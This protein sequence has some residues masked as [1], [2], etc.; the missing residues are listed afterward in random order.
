MEL[1]LADNERMSTSRSNQSILGVMKGFIDAVNE[2]DETVLIPSLLMDMQVEPS[3][4]ALPET[5]TTTSSTTT[6]PEKDLSVIPSICNQDSVNLHTCYAMLKAVK[7]ELIRGSTPSSEAE[8]DEEIPS[9][10]GADNRSRT[11]EAATA[12]AFREHLLG[13][14]GVL[15]QLTDVSKKLTGKYQEELG[16]YQSCFKPK[17]SYLM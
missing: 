15:Q 6:R 16:D 10:I 9:L 17:S 3:A 12:R 14:F 2:M 1:S 4:V 8:E 5:T 11:L 13:L 7:S